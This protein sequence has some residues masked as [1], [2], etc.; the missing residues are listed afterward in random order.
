M[1]R[2]CL[3]LYLKHQVYPAMIIMTSVTVFSEM[4]LSNNQE[5][6]KERQKYTITQLTVKQELQQRY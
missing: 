1:G 2:R 5:K 3:K 6:H 4:F